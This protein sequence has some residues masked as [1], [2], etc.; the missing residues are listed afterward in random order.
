MN[1]YVIRHADAGSRHDWNGNDADRPL[2]PL[3]H[4]QA[5]ALGE[6]LHQRAIGIDVVVTSPLARAWQTAADVRAV[7]LP[8]GREPEFCDLLAPEAGRRRKLT[9]FLNGLGA[10][11]V[12]IVGHDP[13]L[14]SYIGWLIGCDPENVRL[15]K[16]GAALVRFEDEPAKGEGQLGWVITPEWFL[17]AEPEAVAG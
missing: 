15:E 8:D 6:A 9:K 4:R 2:S 14:P 11:N 17:T 7:V 3:G 5:K 13:D 12:A 1:L 10:A 16:G